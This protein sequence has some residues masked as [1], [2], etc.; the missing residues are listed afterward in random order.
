M[1]IQIGQQFKRRVHQGVA[2]PFRVRR[3]DAAFNGAT[4][5]D[6]PVPVNLVPD[7]REESSN[8]A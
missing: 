6:V 7:V 2:I 8:R 5:R 3:L 4:R 1:V